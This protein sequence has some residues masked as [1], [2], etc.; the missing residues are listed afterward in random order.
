[1]DEL[2]VNEQTADERRAAEQRA[3]DERLAEQE[4]WSDKTINDEP[5]IGRRGWRRVLW[6]TLLLVLV[7]L[8][9]TLP[10]LVNVS[11]F[12]HR[13]ASSIAGA[14]GRPVR[15]DNISLHMLPWPGFT[16]DNFVVYEDPAF[17]AEPAMRANRVDAR[18]RVAS[19]W[20]RRVEVSRITLYSPTV[21]LVRNAAG[22]WNMQGV[23]TQAAQVQSA[24]TPQ[25]TAGEAPRFPYIEGSDA[26]VN[27]KLG[28]TKTPYALVDAEFAL[29][30]PTA[31]EWHLRMAGKP[32]RS[33]TDVSDI[34]NV[35]M[36]ATLRRGGGNTAQAPFTLQASWKP[37]PMGEASKLLVGRDAGW[38]GTASAEMAVSGTPEAMHVTTDLHVHDLRRAEFVPP[39]TMQLDAH[40]EAE[41]VGMA[42]RLS[43][44]RCTLP[45]NPNSSL[46]NAL[47]LDASSG[48]P[49]PDVLQ[50]RAEVPNVTEVR[51]AAVRVELKEG[52]PEWA[53]RWMRLFS[54]RMQP[55]ATVGGSFSLLWQRDPAVSGDGWSGA[56]VCACTLPAATDA[57]ALKERGTDA[58]HWT[59]SATHGISDAVH[60]ATAQ[61]AGISV[62]ARPGQT[63]PAGDVRP[64]VERV[65]AK[66]SVDGRADDHGMSLRYGD[67]DLARLFGNIVPSLRDDLPG[68]ATGPVMSSRTWGAAQTWESAT[69]VAVPSRPRR[70]RG[71]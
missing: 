38:R 70:G 34:G 7:I 40:C 68:D 18:I 19:L 71:R 24:P 67:A 57:R 61:D 54:R 58:T 44:V 23:V 9:G 56:V 42:H 63:V 17:G 66:T 8:L 26:R 5:V 20:R 30:L 46:L 22:Y 14:I 28:D 37:T 13:V 16:I 1:M 27:V 48:V 45:T 51:G 65:D 39:D 4:R 62:Q 60:V 11:R 15:F 25:T 3:R 21:N 47:H 69:P 29:W 6:A 36:E 32:L 64:M 55:T 31:Q 10:P 43:G 52:S 53:L 50:L 2:T 35:R 59:I 41:A 33:D 49:T 12:Q